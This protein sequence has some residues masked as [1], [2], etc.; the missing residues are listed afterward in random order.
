M[1]RRKRSSLLRP[2]RI[3]LPILILI[4]VLVLINTNILIV[5]FIDTTLKNINCATDEQIKQ[6]SGV[7]G[8]KFLLINT[9]KVENNLIDK[10]LC[11]KKVE[12]LR[13]FPNK[14]SLNVSG[15]EGVAILYDLKQKDATISAFLDNIATPSAESEGFLV[16]E[17][18][19]IFSKETANLNLPL[20]FIQGQKLSLGKGEGLITENNL[21]ILNTIKTIGLEFEKALILDNFLIIFS[22]P[23]VVFNLDDNLNTQIASLQLIIQK[24]KMDSSQL[25]FIDLRFDKPIVRFAPKKK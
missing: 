21:K 15:R 3:I 13:R 2:I 1:K 4:I 6:S 22:Y 7:N 16:D 19:V 20:L 8:Q 14:V 9:S 5:K 12:F 23:K 11:I 10:Y 24:A 25:E 18:G 17:E